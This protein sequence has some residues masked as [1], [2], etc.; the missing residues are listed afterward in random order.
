MSTSAE[1]TP[2]S[3]FAPGV[4]LLTVG[5]VLIVT[6]VAFES[7]AVATVMPLVEQDLG[8]IWLY[9]WV[10]SAFFLGN[11][12]GVVL[13]GGAADRMRP[14]IPFAIGLAM[15]SVGLVIGGT[16]GSMLVL[17]L[18]R[19]LQGLGA[20]AMPAISY[21]CIGRGYPPDQRPRMFALISTAW[22]VPSVIGPTV[23][24]ALGSTVGWRWVFLGLLPLCG[25]I[26]LLALL[27]VRR[28]GVPAGTAQPMRAGSALLVAGGAAMLLAGS[29]A[30][31]LAVALPLA[32]AGAVVLLPAFR[33]LTPPGTLRGRPG[34]PATVLVRG[35]LTFGFF[36]ADAYVPFAITS[37]RGMPAFVGGLALTA[38]TFTW[39]LASWMQARW[40]D[41][42]GPR[43]LVI[44]GL[45]VIG[46]G[47]L[48]MLT[49]LVPGIPAAIGLVAWGIAGFGIG[50]GYAPL[51]LVTLGSAPAGEEGAVTAALQLSEL[52]GTALGTGVAGVLVA[53]GIRSLDSDRAGLV[54]VFVMAA[55]VSFGGA[56]L[57]RRVPATVPVQ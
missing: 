33:R 34:L 7:L 1:T 36:A 28:I 46:A 6:L 20:G 25:V 53:V 13:A 5:M 23:A 27:G 24:G 26:G 31:Q 4:R 40:I 38:A 49:V 14:A 2:S 10:F 29:G 52:L 11:L 56:W 18:G 47:S 35:L 30:R 54:A 44:S 43:H 22:V 55:A 19:A 15:F 16:A 37:V 32:V 41:R 9:G 51:A 21:V 17:V 48:A 45:I 42:V 57:A 3:V 50:L 8:D 39:T 12:V